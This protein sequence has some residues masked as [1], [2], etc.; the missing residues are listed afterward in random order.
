MNIHGW[1]VAAACTFA[2][3]VQAAPPPRASAPLDVAGIMKRA[4]SRHA[5]A[6]SGQPPP[7]GRANTWTVLR[8]PASGRDLAVTVAEKLDEIGGKLGEPRLRNRVTG[9]EFVN[10]G[11]L[12]TD[13][14]GVSTRLAARLAGGDLVV[15]VPASLLAIS[16]YPAVL[17]PLI[18][19]EITPVTPPDARFPQVV[20][21]GTNYLVAWASTAGVYAARVTPEGVLA[22]PDG[23]L[24]APAETMPEGLKVDVACTGSTC[25]VTWIERRVNTVYVQ[26][27]GEWLIYWTGPRV[28]LLAARVTPAGQPLDPGGLLVSDSENCG[29]ITAP[30]EYSH[31][32]VSVAQDGTNF[33]LVWSQQGSGLGGARVGPDGTVLEVDA[34]PISTAVG[35][36]SFPSVAFDGSLYLVSWV[37]GDFTYNR[38]L[39]A[40]LD[41][42]GTVL[43][44][45]GLLVSESGATSAYQ[46]DELP[47]PSVTRDGA[48][49]VVT[50]L[51]SRFVPSFEDRDVYS[52]R[53]SGEGVVLD[54]GG[55]LLSSGAGPRSSL[56]LV[57]DGRQPVVVWNAC[58]DRLSSGL[59]PPSP[60]Y[61]LRLATDGTPVD[62]SPWLVGD[63]GDFSIASDGRGTSLVVHGQVGQFITTWIP[64]V[65]PPVISVPGEVWQA[66]TSV[67]GARVEF[68]AS[69]TD[70]TSGPVPT[71]C[72]PASGSQFPLGATQV[73]CTAVDQGGNV[74]TASFSVKVTFD[75]SGVLSPL[76]PDGSSVFKLG[77]TI[78]V[79]FRLT[80]ASAAITDLVAKGSVTAIVGGLDVAAASRPASGQFRY[81]P[82]AGKYVLGLGTRGLTAGVWQLRIE[83]G[84]GVERT[85]RFSLKP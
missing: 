43:D 60:M 64:D 54:V 66:A 10:T 67:G 26:I 58:F 40:R 20:F 78:P 80:G 3:A 21:D 30:C 31:S 17:D 42:A 55:R 75:W 25:L 11:A 32:T 27:D 41:T 35:D 36:P 19:P 68:S 51:D 85:V 33:L 18:G 2:V 57:N 16:T 44:P 46:F 6:R 83:M 53:V 74:G 65:E 61:G 5:S 12:W 28:H 4:E 14:A 81:D 82:T 84:D 23:I 24:V 29:P 49:F 7:S 34:I 56:A 37:N 70:A 63:A 50:W 39:G 72:S 73:T 76:S 13:A 52:A 69:A 71:T 1:I 47:H 8:K 15:I 45:G 79:K 9:R 48:S 22:D 77:S 38:I 62:A 59:C